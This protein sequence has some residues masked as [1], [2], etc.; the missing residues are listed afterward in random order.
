MGFDEKTVEFLALGADEGLEMADVV[1]V[2][3]GGASQIGGGGEDG[4]RGQRVG[5]GHDSRRRRAHDRVD[6]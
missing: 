6:E 1:L 2:L 4:L 3:D 5:Q